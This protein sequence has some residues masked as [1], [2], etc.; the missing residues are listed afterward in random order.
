MVAVLDTPADQ[1]ITGSRAPYYLV[2]SK[3]FTTI[4][5]K[6]FGSIVLISDTQLLL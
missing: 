6:Y 5:F 3:S 4:L 1:T 2:T